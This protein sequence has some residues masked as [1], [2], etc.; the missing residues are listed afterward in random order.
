MADPDKFTRRE[1][2]FIEAL[3]QAALS[4]NPNPNRVGCPDQRTLEAV[5]HRQ[6]PMMDPVIDHVWQCSPCAQEVLRLRSA[7][8][9]KRRYWMTA[10][11]MAAAIAIVSIALVRQS[12]APPPQAAETK[13]IA[14]APSAPPPEEISIA[15]LDLRPFSPTRGEGKKGRPTLELKRGIVEL[16]LYLP[17]GLEEGKYELRVLDDQFQTRLTQ[18]V[19]ATMSNYVVKI[20][21]KLDL[22]SFPPGRHQLALRPEGE[23]WR[24]FPLV[25]E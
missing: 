10:G 11:G 4:N 24:T 17:P 5:A 22:R 19:S 9:R 8:G 21:T 2:R 13:T 1:Q 20:Q 15:T 16:N 7:A 6:V 14:P 12:P 25:L 3:R 18:A 23:E